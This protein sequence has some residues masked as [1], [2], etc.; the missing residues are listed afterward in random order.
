MD[1]AEYI[2]SLLPAWARSRWAPPASQAEGQGAA[3]AGADTSGPELWKLIAGLGVPV[4]AGRGVLY[5]LRRQWTLKTAESAAL[6]AHGE[7]MR[8]PRRL[9]E[10]HEAYQAR[11]MGL[12]E[13]RLWSATRRGMLALMRAL[14]QPGADI[15]ELFTVNQE[16][17]YDGSWSFDGSRTYAS[18]NRWAEFAILLPWSEEPFSATTYQRWKVEVDAIKPAH[19]KLAYFGFQLPMSDTWTGNVGD[20]LSV[21]ATTQRRYDGTWAFDGAGPFGPTVEVFDA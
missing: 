13:A 3:Q 9:A 5:R 7:G 4:D 11:L 10:S 20:S 8:A 12:F 16:Q 14:G 2:W 17:T 6:D 15:L 18:P 21:V 1:A 19:A